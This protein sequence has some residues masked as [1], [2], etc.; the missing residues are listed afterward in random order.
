MYRRHVGK[1]KNENQQIQRSD[2]SGI[3][4]QRSESSTTGLRMGAKR[5]L[6]TYS[7]RKP[8]RQAAKQ[9]S[10]GK[11]EKSTRRKHIQALSPNPL[12][13]WQIPPSSSPIEASPRSATSVRLFDSFTDLDNSV[14]LSPIRKPSPRRNKTSFEEEV[15]RFEDSLLQSPLPSMEKLRT[16]S[17]PPIEELV[18]VAVEVEEDPVVN[19]DSSDDRISES[20]LS[21]EEKNCDPETEEEIPD[22]LQ[23]DCGD[24]ET[25]NGKEN[26]EIREPGHRKLSADYETYNAMNVGY[27][28]PEEVISLSMDY[29]L[30]KSIPD[31]TLDKLEKE[32]VEKKRKPKKE[33]RFQSTAG[34][35]K[36]S[37]GTSPKNRSR[38]ASFARTVSDTIL[39]SNPENDVSP[40]SPRTPAGGR[41]RSLSAATAMR[42]VALAAAKF[43]Q[44][45]NR[46][47]KPNSQSKE[48]RDLI[49]TKLKVWFENNST[50]HL[51][52]EVTEENC[53]RLDKV[54]AK[55]L[56][57][58]YGWNV[59]TEG[60]VGDVHFRGDFKFV[61]E[62]Q[63]GEHAVIK[64]KL[65]NT[66]H[67]QKKK[68]KNLT[69]KTV[70]MRSSKLNT[71]RALQDGDITQYSLNNNDP[72]NVKMV[73]RT[74]LDL[75]A[76][77]LMALYNTKHGTVLDELCDNLVVPPGEDPFV[78]LALIGAQL[79]G[80]SSNCTEY[81]TLTEIE[82]VVLRSY[83]Q[84][85][86]D[87]DRDM[88]FID[89]PD[90]DSDSI[91]EYEK[92]FTDWGWTNLNDD[93]KR[94]G[95]IYAA[96]CGSCRD[97][98]PLGSRSD[99]SARTLRKWI[100]TICLLMCITSTTSPEPSK[101]T[102]YRGLGGGALPESV[103]NYHKLLNKS[104]TLSW[105]APSSTSF[106]EQSSR[107]YMLGT[108]VNSVS[109]PNDEKPGTIM[110]TI[111]KG[112]G[113]NLQTISQ[114]PAEAEILVPPLTMFGINSVERDAANP[115]KCGLNIDM[116][117]I[118]PLGENSIDGIPH[119][120][121]FFEKVKREAKEASKSLRKTAI[122]LN[123]TTPL[124]SEERR[125][126]VFDTEPEFTFDDEDSEY[127]NTVCTHYEFNI[128]DPKSFIENE[129]R[130][131]KNQRDEDSDDNSN[132][133]E[134]VATPDEVQEQ[135]S[136]SVFENG[137]SLSD[138][139]LP[140]TVTRC[141]TIDNDGS[142][143]TSDAATEPILSDTHVDDSK[144]SN[145]SFSDSQSEI[146]LRESVSEFPDSCQAD[147][148]YSSRRREKISKT[149]D[150][151]QHQHHETVAVTSHDSDEVLNSDEQHQREDQIIASAFRYE[152]E[153]T[154][155]AN[156]KRRSN[157]NTDGDDDDNDDYNNGES[158]D[159]DEEYEESIYSDCSI[160]SEYSDHKV[161]T[162]RSEGQRTRP[163]IPLLAFPSSQMISLAKC[164]STATAS[165]QG[166]TSTQSMAN[167]ANE[168]GG[169]DDRFS[170]RQ[171]FQN[172]VPTGERLLHSLPT[173]LIPKVVRNNTAVVGAGRLVSTP[174]VSEGTPTTTNRLRSNKLFQQV[175]SRQVFESTK[176][177]SLGNTAFKYNDV[178]IGDGDI[179]DGVLSAPLSPREPP[180][181]AEVLT[182]KR[183]NT[184]TSPRA[185]RWKISEVS[186]R[187]L[188][189]KKRHNK[190]AEFPSSPLSPRGM[191]SVVGLETSP[192]VVAAV[193]RITSP[194]ITSPLM[195]ARATS[196][197]SPI[198]TSSLLSPRVM[199]PLMSPRSSHH[200][201]ESN[202]RSYA[203]TRKKQLTS[204]SSSQT[205]SPHS[206][207]GS[208]RHPQNRHPQNASPRHR[209]VSEKPGRRMESMAHRASPAALKLKKTK[210]PSSPKSDMSP[211]PTTP[212]AIAETITA[213]ATSPSK[214]QNTAAVLQTSI[215]RLQ[216]IIIR[217]P[218]DTDL[219]E[220]FSRKLRDI[221]IQ[222][223][224]L[225]PRSE[226]SRPNTSRPHRKRYMTRTTAPPRLSKNARKRRRREAEKRLRE[227][228]QQIKIKNDQ[229]N[230]SQQR[231]MSMKKITPSTLSDSVCVRVP[232]PSSVTTELVYKQHYH[233]P[234]QDDV[235]VNDN[236]MRGTKSVVTLLLISFSIINV[237]CTA[238]ESIRSLVVT[239]GG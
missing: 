231:K 175:P 144:F 29:Y 236:D 221:R 205:A 97:Q 130:F 126:S 149:K 147:V 182:R 30:I 112:I 2:S 47:K 74:D 232:P 229:S 50:K 137:I 155:E 93:S 176:P 239:T 91:S 4:L 117:C 187:S 150:Q 183:L 189:V 210:E 159:E 135:Q 6:E 151:Q 107:Q 120:K 122:Q 109:K 56:N 96:L 127:S 190:V 167:L 179:G 14:Q 95:S 125:T 197:L 140:L 101:L 79:A 62:T 178:D 157:I 156:R 118:G 123:C 26:N 36:K 63:R 193:P 69:Q 24:A 226:R 214:K 70:S 46:K 55:V 208:P 218:G 85:P 194:Q 94:N 57:F 22:A 52:I 207:S 40:D 227:R 131:I 103:V 51:G 234:Q 102:L 54:S 132:A 110:F 5:E 143:S 21:E 106:E 177:P 41:R 152:G 33:L 196:P 223:E 87:I 73:N 133:T 201:E 78:S 204:A 28:T 192:V 34:N 86:S 115:F 82:L 9:N 53:F 172:S 25:E 11:D 217:N 64:K 60:A 195:S 19:N 108:A 113:L 1:N 141:N 200:S 42:G 121:E 7:E 148:I 84:K 235:S 10:F 164:E 222:E 23:T 215:R 238:S 138:Y 13:G 180:L 212:T 71:D 128:T 38:R 39:R 185:P 17:P 48:H 59:T 174:I 134:P 20:S 146:L 228:Q 158:D 171:Q 142:V 8:W 98:G 166:L 162:R 145:A 191:Q 139:K 31:L 89:V 3:S 37:G 237:F 136:E 58:Q 206:R 168:D 225:T 163:H 104:H 153:K 198:S 72:R 77:R 181:N 66:S 27:Q 68:V 161:F 160:D 92:E 219:K 90:I 43:K 116:T 32:A 213:T 99:E 76:H 154:R 111:S 75:F 124:L 233:R 170:G 209:T 220:E 114:Y 81:P 173:S 119:L 83:T 202:L 67:S 16:N 18:T 49:Y 199:S 45:R 80:S 169:Y 12:L 35:E 216:S 61:A 165:S 100:K 188:G 44:S 224:Q 65:V 211:E 186:P 88:G 129:L 203:P 105:T 230:K 15:Q 184:L